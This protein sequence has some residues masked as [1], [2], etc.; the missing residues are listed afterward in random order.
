VRLPRP[1]QATRLG[2]RAHPR[3]FPTHHVF[4]C[5]RPEAPCTPRRRTSRAWSAGPPRAP[6]RARRSRPL[7]Y[8]ALGARYFASRRIEGPLFPPPTKQAAAVACARRPP[9][10][11]ACVESRR[12]RP[13]LASLASIHLP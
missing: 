5:P 8:G 7:A 12:P 13:R 3:A 4:Q 6:L 2:V 10:A 11:P 1:R 9:L